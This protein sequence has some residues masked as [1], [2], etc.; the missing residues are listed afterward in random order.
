VELKYG[1]SPTSNI[2]II[3]IVISA[4]SAYLIKKVII[5]LESDDIY[6]EIMFCYQLSIMCS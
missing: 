6:L 2:I 4:L 3:V 5:S 1:Q